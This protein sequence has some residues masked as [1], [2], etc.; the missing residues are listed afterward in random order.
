MDKEYTDLQFAEKEF[1]RAYNLV[2]SVAKNLVLL[3]NK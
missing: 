1:F 3:Q 2:G